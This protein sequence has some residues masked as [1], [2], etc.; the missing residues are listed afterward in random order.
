MEL[1][2]K[3]VPFQSIMQAWTRARQETLT[4]TYPKAA[5][6]YIREQFGS[7]DILVYNG[8][9]NRSSDPNATLR[10]TYRAVFETNVFGVVVV[11]DAFLPLLRASKYSDRRIG[12]VTSGLG[13]IG[14]AYSPTSE[15]NAKIWELPAY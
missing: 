5:A 15:Y 7:L 8:G 12:D 4:A 14:I 10:D 3:I 6:I 2:I 13:Q 1:N 11:I 9:I